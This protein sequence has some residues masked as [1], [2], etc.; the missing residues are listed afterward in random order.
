MFGFMRLPKNYSDTEFGIKFRATYCTLCRELGKNFEGFKVINNYDFTFWAIFI[1][2]LL[3]NHENLEEFF[4]LYTL[5]KKF[6]F[7]NPT[8]GITKAG[9]YTKIFLRLKLIDLWQDFPVKQFN[10]QGLFESFLAE[11]QL[12]EKKYNKTLEFYAEISGGI[13]GIIT[14]DTLLDKDIPLNKTLLAYELAFYVGRLIYLLDALHDFKKD[15]ILRRFNGIL[16]AYPEL[17]DRVTGKAL[18]EINYVLFRHLE[19]IKDRLSKLDLNF[20]PEMIAI[21]QNSYFKTI[22]GFVKNLP[23][24]EGEYGLLPE[25]WRILTQKP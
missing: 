25:S 11:Q 15:L 1:D 13:L 21:L 17:K 5:K 24:K 4:C 8:Y 23:L 2:T 6:R 10:F 9:Y 3:E 18:Q 20:T 7:K 22:Y 19:V 12:R 14:A 16:A